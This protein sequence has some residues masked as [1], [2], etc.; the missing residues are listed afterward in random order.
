MKK[1]LITVLVLALLSVFSANL[2]AQDNRVRVLV[3]GVGEMEEG[4]RQGVQRAIS[5]IE[6][7]LSGKLKNKLMSIKEFN[8]VADN[9]KLDVIIGKQNIL[10]KYD[11]SAIVEYGKQKGCELVLIPTVTENSVV[12]GNQTVRIGGIGTGEVS[13]T[14]TISLSMDLY[15]LKTQ[16]ILTSIHHTSTKKITGVAVNDGRSVQVGV[17]KGQE[18]LTDDLCEDLAT[19][20]VNELRH[21]LVG[22][23]TV[24]AY[25]AKGVKKVSVGEHVMV[26]YGSSSNIE[27]DAVAVLSYLDEDGMESELGE[28]IVVSVNDNKA[29][30]KI[31]SIDTDAKVTI[32]SKFTV[33]FELGGILDRFYEEANSL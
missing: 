23:F 6:T 11:D 24:G 26:D 32:K 5:N 31:C 20:C 21:Q 3:L 33:T 14:Y 13:N 27:M 10:Q 9:N 29:K 7:A 8:F 25:V 2:L 30:L 28:A 18:G 1:V 12:Q 4:Y 22:T 17:V 19:K 15:N 16:E